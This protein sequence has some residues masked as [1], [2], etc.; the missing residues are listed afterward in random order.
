MIILSKRA[1]ER[2]T[3]SLRLAQTEV[4]RLGLENRT[5]RSE[6]ADARDKI[7]EIQLTVALRTGREIVDVPART[8]PA[9]L[10]IR[11]VKRT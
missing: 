8:V 9:H 6:L 4:G 2:L 10:M 1:H 3:T 11:K 7:T 5:L